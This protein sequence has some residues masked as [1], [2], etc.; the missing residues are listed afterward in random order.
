MPVLVR[1]RTVTHMYVRRFA[2]CCT[3][4]T[5]R[6]QVWLINQGLQDDTLSHI[7][8]IDAD[9]CVV[10]PDVTCEKLVEEAGGRDIIIAEDMNP[11]SKLSAGVIV[12][13]NTPWYNDATVPNLC[14]IAKKPW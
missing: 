8:W 3:H 7:I 10:R 5:V 1:T 13:A 2:V 4:T 6:R 12:I 14:P 11:V 9:A